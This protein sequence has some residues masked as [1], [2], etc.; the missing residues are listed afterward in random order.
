[1]RCSPRV[2][3]AARLAEEAG[4]DGVFVWDHLIGYNRD[5]VSEWA[6]VGFGPSQVSYEPAILARSSA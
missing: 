4:W 5:L 3:E 1:M 2:A 6:G